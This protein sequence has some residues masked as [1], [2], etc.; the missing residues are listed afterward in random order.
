[1]NGIHEKRPLCVGDLFVRT[2]GANEGMIVR[3]TEMEPLAEAS[4]T[5]I[6]ATNID[7]GHWCGGCKH[8]LGRFLKNYRPWTD[9]SPSV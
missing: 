7:P 4:A 6:R 8:S 2:S 9:P 3:V 5:L 1:M